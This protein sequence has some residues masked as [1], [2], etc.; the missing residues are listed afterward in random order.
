MEIFQ[1]RLRKYR[2]QTFRLA[3]DR[4]L[5]DRDQAVDYVNE[6][7]FVYFWPITGILLP[8]LWVA[9]AGDR[10]VADE[11]DDPGHV[12]WG[13]KDSLLGQRLWYYAKVLRKKATMI[14]LGAAPYFYALS[15]NYGSAEEDYL[16]QYEQGHLTQEAK[17]LYEALLDEG[18]LDT[19]ALR[20]VTHMSS[21]SS[22]GRFTRALSDLQADF[23]ILPVAVTQAGAWHYAFAYDVVA[24]HYPEL[25]EQARTISESDARRKLVELYF[26]SVGAAQVNDVCKLFGWKLAVVDQTIQ[27]LVESG[28]LQRGL[29]LNTRPG[30]WV[31]LAELT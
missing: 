20:R 6:R 9:A 27:H 23:K 28:V 14:S 26:H 7:G 11:H 21:P 12:T 25:P 16:I 13:W 2:A 15:E 3:A 8:S 24:R 18:P 31:G 22:E 29:S 4:R 1:E 5:K 17:V 19:V 10:P 30:E